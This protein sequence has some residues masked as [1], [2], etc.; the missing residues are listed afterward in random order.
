MKKNVKL[1][2][3]ITSDLLNQLKKEAEEQDNS[4]ANVCREKLNS[5]SS[6]NR[7]ESLLLEV[8]KKIG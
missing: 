4:I 5:R 7:I 6:L 3:R 8:N 1:Y 2:L